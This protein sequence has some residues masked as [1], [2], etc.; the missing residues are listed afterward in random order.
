MPIPVISSRLIG[1]FE[2]HP[3]SPFTTGDSREWLFSQ[4]RLDKQR[5]LGGKKKENET[6]GRNSDK[7]FSMNRY[8]RRETVVSS[9]RFYKLLERRGANRDFLPRLS[10]SLV[11]SVLQGGALYRSPRLCHNPDI[12]WDNAT[13]RCRYLYKWT[14][15]RYVLC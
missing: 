13:T 12:R 9:A 2:K 4:T 1:S 7:R 5:M 6:M 11:S 15:L 14:T 3:S 8:R 10:L